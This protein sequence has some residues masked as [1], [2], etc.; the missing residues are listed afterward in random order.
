MGAISHSVTASRHLESSSD[1]AVFPFDPSTVAYNPSNP[2]MIDPTKQY[3]V[4][5][6]EF[7]TREGT[8]DMYGTMHYAFDDI[9][10]IDE[11]HVARIIEKR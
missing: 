3:P 10:E 7:M 5:Y 9:T 11:E 6:Q 1:F 2:G 4:E 8:W